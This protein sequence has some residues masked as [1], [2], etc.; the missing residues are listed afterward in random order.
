MDKYIAG[1]NM[2]R[3]STDIYYLE[4]EKKF[5]CFYLLH[6]V[7]VKRLTLPCLEIFTGITGFNTVNLYAQ[8]N[9]L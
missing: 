8:I 3:A 9:L 5:I 7:N 2:N 1:E 4:R 6:L